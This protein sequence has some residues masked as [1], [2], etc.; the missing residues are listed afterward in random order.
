VANDDGP[1]AYEHLFDHEAHDS[2]TLSHV[3]RTSCC[4]QPSEKRRERL[5][6]TQV[7]GTI[8]DLFDDRLQFGA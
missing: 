1:I 5:R 4:A 2:L 6:E 3:E 7:C 8:V